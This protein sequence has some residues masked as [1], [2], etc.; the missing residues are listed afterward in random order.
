MKSSAALDIPAVA[1]RTLTDDSEEALAFRPGLMANIMRRYR[2]NIALADALTGLLNRQA[3]M[4]MGRERLQTARNCALFYIDLDKFKPVNDTYGHEAGDAAL[5]EAASRLKKAVPATALVAR[6]GGDEFC[7][8]T[9]GSVNTAATAEKIKKALA[10]PLKL[11][12]APEAVKIGASVGFARYSEDG[13]NLDE[14]PVFADK[15]MYHA[16]A[17]SR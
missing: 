16:K 8:L 14:L 13:N 7:V 5:R 1:L 3:F 6:L 4:S 11:P 12:N 10:K 2:M 17:D 9:K 15:N